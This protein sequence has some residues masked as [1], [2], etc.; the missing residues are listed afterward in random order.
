VIKTPTND[1]VIVQATFNITNDWF[2]T[3]ATLQAEAGAAIQ[4]NG[5]EAVPGNPLQRKVS[6]AV[7]TNITVTATLGSSSASL[8]VW[9]IW[10]TI[11]LQFTNT[12]PS[13]LSFPTIFPGNELGPQYYYINTNGVS[14]STNV[15]SANIV[16]G[17]MCGIATITPDQVC[18]II[19]NGWNWVQM[20]WPH[21]YA[22]GAP[23]SGYS[24]SW[25][26]DHFKSKYEAL[27]LDSAN[28][29]YYLDGPTV[30]SFGATNSIEQYCNFYS[31]VTWS[32]S[33]CS[34]TNNFW[35]WQGKWNVD[36]SPQINSVD[37]GTNTINLP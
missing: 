2:V 7:S 18:T 35:H 1:Y 3:N 27:I 28:H 37:L 30:A 31:Y 13:T 16:S 26:N 20:K 11:G 24:L 25:T 6:K 22:D 4:W 9:V 21:P 5:G 10:S 32:N 34:A 36:Q 15:N 19:T 33:I 29:I 12:N 8:N 17:K 14:V 23:Y